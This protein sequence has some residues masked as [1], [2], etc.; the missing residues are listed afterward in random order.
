MINNPSPFRGLGIRIP[1]KGRGGFWVR[2][3]RLGFCVQ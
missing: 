3:D 2:V 1:P